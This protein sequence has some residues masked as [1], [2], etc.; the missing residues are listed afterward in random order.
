[1]MN[2]SIVCDDISHRLAYLYQNTSRILDR[3]ME[4]FEI[5]KPSL[6]VSIDP[7]NLGAYDAALHEIQIMFPS[8]MNKINNIDFLSDGHYY[9]KLNI[10]PRL[11]YIHCVA[12]EL[13]HAVQFHTKKLVIKNNM[14]EWTETSRSIPIIEQITMPYNEYLALP[15][16]Q[17]A[18]VIATDTITKYDWSDYFFLGENNV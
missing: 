1:M 16:E 4:F 15:W 5:P 6:H 13:Q 8:D 18:N 2:Y 11:L 3:M 7:T 10:D 14:I 9:R 17:E 12:H